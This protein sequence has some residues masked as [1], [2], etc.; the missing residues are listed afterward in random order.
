MTT[1]AGWYPDAQNAEQLRWW[2]GEKW[3]SAVHPNPS[4]QA[5]TEHFSDRDTVS[6]TGGSKGRKWPW[7]VGAV[8]GIV[9]LLGIVGSLVS[10]D[11]NADVAASPQSTTAR[12][13]SAPAST[14]IATS[15]VLLPPPVQ[16]ETV[17]TAAPTTLVP[18]VP[19]TTQAPAPAPAPGMTAG[20]RNAVRSAE[21]YLDY[22]S[23]SR[24]GLIDQLVFEDYSFDD[25]SF[26]VDSI[27][28]DWNQQAAESAQS[29][30][31]Y[32]AFSRQGLIDQLV[33]EGFTLEQAQ[34]GVDSVGI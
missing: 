22:S 29:Y 34:Y 2:D 18:V 1:P 15:T 12:S 21:Q 9:V 24:E 6:A 11:E 8:A 30:L 28:P 4:D 7:I 20:Q 10:P 13:S 32:S 31:D 5:P 3:T 27:S 14:T 33:F 25:A 26:A 17:E 23:F 16:V 19:R